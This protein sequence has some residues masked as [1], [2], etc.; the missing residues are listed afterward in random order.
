MAKE[1]KAPSINDQGT[2]SDWV[3]F[4]N[5]T[6]SSIHIKANEWSVTDTLGQ[7]DKFLIPVSFVI[8]S[9]GF[10]VVWCDKFI[11]SFTTQIHA[12]FK[13]SITAGSQLGI[14]CKNKG[15]FKIV[16]AITYNTTQVQDISFGRFPDGGNMWQ[17]FS[18]PTPGAPNN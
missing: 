17:S 10:V 18:I 3:E 16:D 8:P 13:I 4:Y 14:A 1:T 9:H 2:P 15:K 11:P 6:D 5:T 7:P 12:S